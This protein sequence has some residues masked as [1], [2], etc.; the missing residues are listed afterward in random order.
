M[1]TAAVVGVGHEVRPLHVAMFPWLAFGHINP[2]VY[3]AN[4]LAGDAATRVTIVSA[5]GNLPQISPSSLL[6]SLITLLP[7]PLPHIDGLPPG[8]ECT[9]DATFLQAELLKDALDATQPQVVSILRDLAPDLVVYDF[10]YCWLPTVAHKLGIRAV[11]FSVF[12]AASDGYTMVCE[13]RANGTFPTSEELERSPLG[14]PSGCNFVLRPFEARQFMYLYTSFAGKPSVYDRVTRSIREADALL[15]KT[16][17][18]MEGPFCDYIAAQHKKPILLAGPTIP[19]P[20]QQRIGIAALDNE[21]S[22]WLSSHPAGS[23]VFCAFGSETFLTEKEIQE[24]LLGIE[25]TGLPFAVVL[26]FPSP[27]PIQSPMPEGFE[28]RVRGRGVVKTGWVQQR[29]ILGHESVGGF[30]CHSGFGSLI[31]G[32][33]SG[34]Q[35]VLLPLKGDQFLNARLMGRELRVGVEVERRA[36]DGFFRRED[37]C[38]AVRC[39]MVEAD[40]EPGK[41]VRENHERLKQ[42]LLDDKVQCRTFEEDFVK[43]L[44][45]LLV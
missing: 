34:C 15:F 10:S 3:L 44:R 19:G 17:S 35:L 11:Y 18:E 30:L 1:E 28:E 38:K 8:L 32:V 4:K 37:V 20:N 23:V 43:K 45:C 2:Y 33:V 40:K 39:V 42:F 31:E 25:M 24:L 12:S 27:H 41:R 6:P 36:E 16:C 5:P 13:R 14:F 9:T 22:T 29:L 21:W 26:N 7:L